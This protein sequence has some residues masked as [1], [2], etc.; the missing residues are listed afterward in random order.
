ML[1]GIS[2]KI[3]WNMKYS[4]KGIESSGICCFSGFI[5]KGLLKVC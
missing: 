3:S 1:K 4:E 5:A 2:F